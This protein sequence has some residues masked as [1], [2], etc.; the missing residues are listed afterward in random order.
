M[1][2]ETR[3]SLL[4]QWRD[5]RK[6]HPDA[7]VLARVGDF[8]ELFGEDA[9]L[10]VRELGLTPTSRSGPANMPMAGIPAKARDEYVARLV[11]RGH[12]V[13]VLEQVE[14]AADA[15]GTVRRA[16]VE[17]ATP[18]TVLADALLSEGRNNYL[19]ALAEAGDGALGIA[20]ADVSTG[21]VLLA[22]ATADTLAGEL[23]RLAPAELLVANG[24][25]DRPLPGAEGARLTRQPDML[26]DPGVGEDEIRAHYRVQGLEGFGL[27]PR[28]QPA[29]VGALGALLAYLRAVQP[30]VVAHL[31]APR[32]EL[33]GDAMQLDDMTRRNLE[34]VEALRREPGARPEDGTLFAVV[35][36]T[37]TPM[38]TRLLRSWLLRPLVS[39]ERIQTRQQAVAE[40]V[41]NAGLRTRI[42][43][44]LAGVRDVERLAARLSAGR[45]TP[46]E[47]RT[48]GDSLAR[49]PALRGELPNVA[50]DALRKLLRAIDPLDDV[51]ETIA[52]G[53]ADEP[54]PGDG[55]GG[56]IRDGYDAELDRLR[57]LR[58][59]ASAWMARF[60][61]EER[62]RTGITALKVGYHRVF[63]YFLE[64]PKAVLGRVPAGY[65][66]R[67][68]LANAE[69][70]TTPELREWEATALD[71]DDRIAERE[72]VLLDALRAAL[73]AQ[74]RRLQ[75]AALRIATLDVLAA[76]AEG[77]ARGGYVRPELDAGFRL[78]IRGGRHPVVETMMPADRYIPNDVGLD[79]DARVVI[80]TGP[81]M[82]GKSTV[83]RMVG[84][85]QLLAQ[86]GGF[87]PADAARLG[88]VD[89]VFTRVGASDN[90]VRGQS[91]FM[92]EAS[93]CATIL[94]GA[95]ARSLVLMDEVG[96]GTATWDGVSL[97][98]AIVEYLHGVVG[99]KTIFATHYHELT[100]LAERLP[101][102]VNLNVAVREEHDRIVF[103]HQLLPGGADRSYGI[104]VARLAG[105]PPAVIA[106]ARDILR[107]L[108]APAGREVREPRPAPV[109]APPAST[110]PPA[111]TDEE[112]DVAER[113]RGLD[114]DRLTPLAALNELAALRAAL[115]AGAGRRR[116]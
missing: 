48:L 68:T 16:V 8:Y 4:A 65:E 92:V 26:F 78:E 90:L 2:A 62:Q 45:V 107:S 96:R 39:L 38:G 100:D 34:V 35:N 84:L 103:L 27:D 112:R 60:Q 74:R 18:G 29:L 23:A 63:G 77:A 40:L 108:D 83:L 50:T 47:L 55:E 30:G 111:P 115:L 64:V 73:A 72:R 94:N 22:P 37:L 1:A 76:F 113:L 13:A 99:A 75:D 42:R 41:E 15:A 105:V 95:T 57:Q 31:R 97:A 3:P 19:A 56:V 89:R 104:E 53:V 101:G 51:R 9:E 54:G 110:A 71:A 91:T 21:E 20:A 24:W 102:V 58:G 61:A 80:L 70:Y 66:R 25:G 59:G 98:W 49:V 87:V 17:V 109:A 12:R 44:A 85:I 36:R 28:R 10:G 69:R 33:A 46:R 6:R 52:R 11:A 106:R 14:D 114:I 82:A 88:V 93:E 81:N 43:E 79:A 86:V 116:A 7:V 67:Q 5:A 32:V